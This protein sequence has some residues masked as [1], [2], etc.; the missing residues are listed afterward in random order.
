MTRRRGIGAFLVERCLP[1]YPILLTLWVFAAESIA[2]GISG[3][4][5]SWRPSG[6]TFLKILALMAAG[7]F[8]RMVDDQKDLDYDRIHHPTRPLVQRRVTSRE[9]QT[10]M[11]PAAVLALVLASWVSAWAVILLA[12]V[13]TCSLVLWWADSRVRVLRDNAIANL[14]AVVPVQFL[15]TGFA[16][17][18]PTGV[19]EASWG[20]IAL[21]PV[22]FTGALLHAEI[23]RK[24][25]AP[26]GLGAPDRHSY[27]ELI[28][29]TASAVLACGFGLIAVLTE[30]L[31]TRPWSWAEGG[32]PTAWLPLVTA[33][34]PLVSGWMFL[35]GG[36]RD[37]PQA[38]PAVFVVAFLLSVIGQGLGHVQS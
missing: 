15:I 21:V 38:L 20:R 31:V 5:A 30:V 12:A 11:M 8:L 2:V 13:L 3:A 22:V 9:L 19:G 16:M 32:W 27:S 28:G 26:T 29:A 23:A 14:A 7:A 10:A 17:T 35:R 36:R 33:V 4:T 37:H 24:A 6:D 1:V 34:L 18:G 25:T